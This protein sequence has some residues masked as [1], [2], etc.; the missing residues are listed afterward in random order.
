MKKPSF[1]RHSGW[2]HPDMI[3]HP[4]NIIGCGAVGSNVAMMAARM[5]FKKFRL[6]DHDK[7]EDYNLANQ[8]F[9]S[10]HIGR[11]KVEALKEV[12][13]SF[14]PDAEVETFERY[15]SSSA[16]AERVKGYL[17]IAT[18]S[19]KSRKDIFSTFKYNIEIP[20]VIEARLSFSHGEI[21]ILD[22]LNATTN[23]LWTETLVN[24]DLIQE[25]PC[26]QRLCS[27]LVSSVGAYMV[28][29][30]S[31]FIVSKTNNCS[32]KYPYGTIMIMKDF[33][34]IT[35]QHSLQEIN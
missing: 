9:F 29:Y 32:F 10:E 16:D 28:Q 12:I 33:N 6:W 19:M 15:F 3:T 14:N 21:H 7:V 22:P 20:L 35:K 30:L 27:T 1:L 2:I 34:I 5:G 17:I 26:N 13:L 8:Q 25:G 18:D 11:P 24:D 23:K 4:I 31:S